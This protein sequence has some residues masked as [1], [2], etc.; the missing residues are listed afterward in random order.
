MSNKIQSVPTKST[1]RNL[2]I[3]YMNEI[4]A[5]DFRKLPSAISVMLVAKLA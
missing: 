1:S 2:N 4:S 5:R 3:P